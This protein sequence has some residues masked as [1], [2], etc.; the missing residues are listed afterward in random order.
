MANKSILWVDDDA[1]DLEMFSEA[2]AELR[3]GI[4]VLYARN[5][6]EALRLL[7]QCAD[8]NALPR[9][10]ILDMNMPQMGGRETL[11]ALRSNARFAGLRTIV[12]TTS[13]S[14]LDQMICD[15]YGVPLYVKPRSYQQLKETIRGFL[16]EDEGR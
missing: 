5:G 2:V 6:G 4:T 14:P 12:F 8:R 3:L 16:S 1:D 10:V 11:V 15:K 9:L 13:E 7:Q